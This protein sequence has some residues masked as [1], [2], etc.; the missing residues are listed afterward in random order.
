VLSAVS[1]L[2]GAA[3]MILGALVGAGFLVASAAPAA[4][5]TA[6]AASSPKDGA[7]L[8]VA[9]NQIVLEFASP[10][11]TKASHT[12]VRGPDG[13]DYETGTP[14]VTQN[15]LTQQLKPLG[16]AGV[17]KIEFR[18]VAADGHPLGDGIKFTLT[19]PGPAVAGAAAPSAR[20]APYGGVKSLST[21]NDA[22]AWEPWTACAAAVIFAS[23]ALWL[24]RRVTRGLD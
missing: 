15:K 12:V 5:H 21:A 11:L 10:I 24:G 8:D 7:R 23:G 6:L 9:P 18:I 1:R 19:K 14:Q 2:T 20:P 4:A 22:P 17:Y 3:R 16:P 13:R